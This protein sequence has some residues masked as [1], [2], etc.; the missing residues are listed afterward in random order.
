MSGDRLDLEVALAVRNRL[1]R[2]GRE[3]LADPRRR[4]ESNPH[5]YRLCLQQSR[6]PRGSALADIHGGSGDVLQY[7]LIDLAD[8]S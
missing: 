5:C 1:R 6:A 8:A 7:N 3:R 2:N 4:R